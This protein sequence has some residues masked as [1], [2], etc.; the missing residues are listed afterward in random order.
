MRGLALAATALGAELHLVP[1]LG[2][3][4]APCKEAPAAQAVLLRQMRLAVHG[5]KIQALLGG[6]ERQLAAAG[7]AAQQAR[8]MLFHDRRLGRPYRF[9][10]A[11]G[12]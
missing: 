6:G 5:S 1:H 8:A 4:F 3:F 11:Q 7:G 12:V 9:L 10:V 2:P